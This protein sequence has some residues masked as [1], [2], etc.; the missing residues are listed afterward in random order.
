MSYERIGIIGYGVVGEAVEYGFSPYPVKYYDKF[1]PSDTLETV[2]NE[3]DVIFVCLPT[4]YKGEKIDLSI[5][6]GAVEEA[7]KYTNDTNKLL[8]IKSTVI[9]GTTRRL[10]EKYPKTKFA[11]NPEFLTEANYLEDFVNADRHVVGAND[12]KTSLRLTALYKGKWPKTPVFQ[13]DTTTAELS[14]YAANCFLATKVIFA[15]EMYDL[16]EK[17]GIEWNEAKKLVMADHRI[18]PTHLDVTSMRGF[19]GKCFP[20]DAVALLGLFKDLDVDAMLLEAMWNKNLKI[21]KVRDWEDI[22][23][24]KTE[25]E[26][27]E[28]GE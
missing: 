5:I 8:V 18:G 12:N 17:L 25:E 16:C 22:P 4:P 19:S 7:V 11:F 24:V 6:E 10:A 3:S 9:P 28:S 1:K 2:C 15:N 23:F 26:P 27:D 14:K 13:T 20:K 21:R